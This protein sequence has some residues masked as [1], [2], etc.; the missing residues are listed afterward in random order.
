MPD[1]SLVLKETIRRGISGFLEADRAA[2]ATAPIRRRPLVGFADAGHPGLR[3][4]RELVDPEH[5]MPGDFLER[6]TVVVSYFLPFI[7]PVG[8]G[9][10]A[11]RM[12]SNEWAQAYLVTNR[13]AARLNLHL[14]ALLA[15]SGYR[16]A[17]PDPARTGLLGADRLWSRWSQRHLAYFAGLGTFGLNN[18]LIGAE[19]CC[20]RYF[21]IVADLPAK[22][23]EPLAGEYCLYKRDGGC[24]ACVSKCAA[25]ALTVDGFD[26]ERCYGQCLENEAVHPGADVCGKCV[27][28]LPC[29]FRRPD[30]GTN[31]N[32]RNGPRAP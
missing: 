2:N 7:K 4:L 29:S 16:A 12:A 19:G 5:F 11:G 26:R 25:A 27:T 22:P 20:G 15:E 3:R 14:V 1:K 32:G 21:S 24:K 17:A 28:G 23:D 30:R 9:N 6:A 31:R 18:M 13:L 10:V 8:D